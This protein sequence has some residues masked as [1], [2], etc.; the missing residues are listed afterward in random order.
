MTSILSRMRRE[1]HATDVL[2]RRGK[3][4]GEGQRVF[5]RPAGLLLSVAKGEV[6]L[7]C[8]GTAYH[9]FFGQ[10]WRNFGM[11]NIF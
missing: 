11:L 4:K 9:A 8:G 10:W 7:D 3:D 1:L 6:A 2:D 5:W